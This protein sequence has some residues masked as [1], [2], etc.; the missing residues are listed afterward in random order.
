MRR[1]KKFQLMLKIIEQ[2]RLNVDQVPPS[3]LSRAGLRGTT[4]P[5][6]DT[7]R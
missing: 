6:Y 2:E 1:D 5:S 4:V 3:G 7:S